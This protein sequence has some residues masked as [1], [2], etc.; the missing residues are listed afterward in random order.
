MVKKIHFIL[1]EKK[2][3]MPQA[4]Y[5]VKTK[6]AS[7]NILITFLYQRFSI[8]MPFSVRFSLLFRCYSCVTRAFV[9]LKGVEP[10]VKPG[11]W[12]PKIWAQLSL[13]YVCP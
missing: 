5:F 3:W 12:G 9:I 13:R 11:V 1:N 6:N 10:R 7:Q 8:K 2:F 4:K